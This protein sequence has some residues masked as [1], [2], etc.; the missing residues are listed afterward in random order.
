MES[1]AKCGHSLDL[2]YSRSST[3]KTKWNL[4]GAASTGK[5]RRPGSSETHRK[6]LLSQSSSAS[7]WSSITLI[8]L[9]RY[10][11]QSATCRAIL[12]GQSWVSRQASAMVSGPTSRSSCSYLMAS[13]LE[14]RALVPQLPSELVRQSKTNCTTL[15]R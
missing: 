12:T 15:A 14:K 10:I 4:E 7:S 9:L 13:C 1:L 2:A 3:T 6:A 5:T 8:T 11:S